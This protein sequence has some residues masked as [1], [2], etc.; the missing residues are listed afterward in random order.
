M[1]EAKMN[2]VNKPS[3]EGI[4]RA[5]AVIFRHYEKDPNKEAVPILKE[6]VS[7]DQKA[8]QA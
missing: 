4:A 6:T 7:Q 3:Q 5:W 1:S 8:E 2:F